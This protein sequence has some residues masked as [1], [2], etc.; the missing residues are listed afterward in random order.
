MST[1]DEHVDLLLA[2][3]SARPKA[4]VVRKDGSEPPRSLC[5]VR[6]DPSSAGA[7]PDYPTCDKCARIETGVF[8]VERRQVP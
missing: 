8:T 7:V 4:H 3:G 2:P 1:P 5:G 6:L